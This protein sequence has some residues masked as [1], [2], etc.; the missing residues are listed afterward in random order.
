MSEGDQKEAQNM[1]VETSLSEQMQKELKHLSSESKSVARQYKN[2]AKRNKKLLKLI[3][4]KEKENNEELKRE[5]ALHSEDID[6]S[7]AMRKAQKLKGGERK[8]HALSKEEAGLLLKMLH[9]LNKIAEQN[10]VIASK[11]TDLHKLIKET[12]S[13]DIE[14]FELEGKD[15]K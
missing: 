14:D 5:T 9:E 7:E 15:M 13:K 1:Q 3:S 2:L 8:E 12:Y 11:H 6:V 4:T 10:K